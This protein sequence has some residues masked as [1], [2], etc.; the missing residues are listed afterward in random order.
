MIVLTDLRLQQLVPLPLYFVVGVGV[1][2]G[3]CVVVGFAVVEGKGL[4]DGDIRIGAVGVAVGIN[5]GEGV[6]VEE[7]VGNIS[8]VGVADGIKVGEG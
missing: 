3:N 6:R 4:P 1:E 8:V 5:A 7:G 2:L